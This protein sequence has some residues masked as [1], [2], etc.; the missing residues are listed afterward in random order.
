MMCNMGSQDWGLE[1][2][3]LDFQGA[4]RGEWRLCLSFVLG[5]WEGERRKMAG[6]DKCSL[7]TPDHQHLAQVL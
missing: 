4:E 1:S 2:Q 3:E 7:E 5:E 6:K